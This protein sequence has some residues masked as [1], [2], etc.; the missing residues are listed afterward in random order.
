MREQKRRA[1][2]NDYFVCP[3]CGAEVSVGARCCPECGSDDNTGW[4]EDADKWAAGTPVYGED[5]EF[6][7]DEFIRREFTRKQQLI[8]G[9]PAGLFWALATMLLLAVLAG[10]L[11]FSG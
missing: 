9:L 6:D 3:H 4:A 5:G 10:V 11:L 8:L 7:Y 2:R 1:S